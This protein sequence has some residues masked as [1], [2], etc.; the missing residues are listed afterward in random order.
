MSIADPESID[1]LGIDPDT[2]N[3][4]LIISDDLDWAD[5]AAHINALQQKIGG[6]IGFIKSGQVEKNLPEAEGR[7]PRIGV[8]QQYEPPETAIQILD[9]MGQQLSSLGIDFGYGPL[10]D[11]Y[12]QPG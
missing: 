3:P 8:I 11:G 9:Q 7:Q 5:V 6:Y 12:E 10:P 2:G 4:L 1:A